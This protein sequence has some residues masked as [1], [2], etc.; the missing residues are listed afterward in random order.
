[1]SFAVQLPEVP[2]DSS[3]SGC[4]LFEWRFGDDHAGADGVQVE[5]LI[6]ILPVGDHDDGCTGG[7]RR[8]LYAGR[9]NGQD[10]DGGGVVLRQLLADV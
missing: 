5:R 1:M 2:D 8:E 9:C 6:A 3:N 7:D 10:G 4:D